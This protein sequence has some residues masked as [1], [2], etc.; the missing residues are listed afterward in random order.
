MSNNDNSII[1]F[2]LAFGLAMLFLKHIRRYFATRKR[3]SSIITR[4]IPEPD[5]LFDVNEPYWAYEFQCGK[6]LEAILVILVEESPWDWHSR[7]SHWYGDYL[8]SRPME[9]VRVR[10]HEWPESKYTILLQIDSESAAERSAIDED[11]KVIFEKIEAKNIHE[12]EP[13]D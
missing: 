4:R 11:I 3:K 12:T 2:A 9:G 13:Y 8:N 10:I 5:P 1:W 6:S 7:D